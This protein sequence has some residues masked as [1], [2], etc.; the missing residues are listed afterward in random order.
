MGTRGTRLPISSAVMT[1][2]TPGSASAAETSIDADAAMGD[3]AAQ[4][5]GVQHA[6][7][8]EIVDI[9]PRPRS[10]AQIF[11]PFDRAADAGS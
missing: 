1:E 3:G 2:C 6:L 8:R 10:E 5:R 4:D 11:E 7:A 9:A